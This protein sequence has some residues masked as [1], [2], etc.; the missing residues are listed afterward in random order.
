MA[1]T[2]DRLFHSSDVG[3]GSRPSHPPDTRRSAPTFTRRCLG[4]GICPTPSSRF[5]SRRAGGLMTGLLALLGLMSWTLP[6]SATPTLTIEWEFVRGY[7]WVVSTDLGSVVY[8]DRI[9]D[10]GSSMV[11][12]S[13]FASFSSASTWTLSGYLEIDDPAGTIETETSLQVTYCDLDS[14]PT[15]SFSIGALP[16]LE[17]T[18]PVF[19]YRLPMSS[20]AAGD[21]MTGNSFDGRVDV[22]LTGT[23]QASVDFYNEVVHILGATQFAAAGKVTWLA[24]DGVDALGRVTVTFTPIIANEDLSATTSP[25]TSLLLGGGG[26]TGGIGLDFTE[27]IS[28]GGEVRADFQALT[29]AE[30]KQQAPSLFSDIGALGVQFVGGEAQVWRIDFDGDAIGAVTATFTYDDLVFGTDFDET[31]LEVV[32]VHDDGS[33]EVVSGED[34][35]VNPVSNTVT[36]DTT[37]FSDFILVAVPEPGFVVSAGAA[38]AT[39]AFIAA[40]RRF[41]LRASRLLTRPRVAGWRRWASTDRCTQANETQPSI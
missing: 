13:G 3:H 10:A 38:L 30:F 9:R 22:T 37:G 28:I 40:R 35:T 11:T 18:D 14:S 4:G 26:V 5:P 17:F 15:A 7:Y 31:I 8:T 23:D 33:V 1:L 36:F 41:Q 24:P 25:I 12:P 20:V 27:G 29:A 16:G 19:F 39:L 34:V 6:A 32:H 21:R 2:P